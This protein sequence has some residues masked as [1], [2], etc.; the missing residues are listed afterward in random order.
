MCVCIGERERERNTETQR[1]DFYFL[2]NKWQGV[3]HWF[4]MISNL[5]VHDLSDIILI[6]GEFVY[7][8]EAVSGKWHHNCCATEHLSI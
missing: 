5:L 1:D 2:R 4:V 3:L 8:E 6:Q 7:I